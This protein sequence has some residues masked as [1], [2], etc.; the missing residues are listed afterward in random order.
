MVRANCIHGDGHPQLPCSFVVATRTTNINTKVKFRTYAVRS[1]RNVDI[2]VVDA[3]LATCASQ[4]SFLPVSVGP[5]LREQEYIRAEIGA[6]NPCKEVISEAHGL[7][8]GKRYVASLLS[9]GSGHPGIIS[10]SHGP[11][12]L[13]HLLTSSE[14]TA[15]DVEMQ[16]GHLGI[17]SRF[18]V[19]QGLQNNQVKDYT[20]I[21][22]ILSHAEVYVEEVEVSRKIDDCVERLRLRQGLASLEQLSNLFIYASLPLIYVLFI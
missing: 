19:S 21:C 9:I 12:S 6:N 2:T 10:L 4:P 5:R 18:S 14:E 17:Y 20:N 16:A 11:N 22:H 7:F 8:S 1:E 3:I 13:Y 15:Q